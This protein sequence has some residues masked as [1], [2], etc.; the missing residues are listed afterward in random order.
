MDEYESLNHTRWECKYHGM[1][2]S[3]YRGVCGV[4]E[5]AELRSLG[6]CKRPNSHKEFYRIFSDCALITDRIR[7][8]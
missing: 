4:Q 3:A 7:A 5:Y 6:Q 1:Q 8:A 2:C